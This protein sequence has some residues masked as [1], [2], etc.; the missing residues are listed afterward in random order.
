G[1][2]ASKGSRRA[3]AAA[4]HDRRSR[5]AAI[6]PRAPCGLTPI[7]LGL[8]Y[9]ICGCS[10]P[11]DAPPRDRR[12]ACEHY[13]RNYLTFALPP[14]KLAVDRNS[15][16]GG[17][18]APTVGARAPSGSGGVREDEVRSLRCGESGGHEFLRQLWLRAL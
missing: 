4:A 9:P 18:R 6:F 5:V 8:L 7:A 16:R 10:S 11:A 1:R 3:R 15:P 2:A 14:Q 17:A 13:E 12:A